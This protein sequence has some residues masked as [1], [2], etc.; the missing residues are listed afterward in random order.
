[1]S[2]RPDVVRCAVSGV[3]TGVVDFR[4]QRNGVF[5]RGRL[6]RLD[7]CDAHPELL[8][9]AEHASQPAS[10]ACPIC[11]TVGG[12]VLVTYVFGTRMP[13]SGRCIMSERELAKL[14]RGKQELAGYVVEV[15]R[16]CSWNHLLRSFPV[17]GRGR[18]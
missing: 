13:P 15:C 6:S 14:A 5:K 7:V 1:V 10:E 9:N 11:E 16:V 18:R 12:L 3:P 8:R 4:L 2:F 17:G